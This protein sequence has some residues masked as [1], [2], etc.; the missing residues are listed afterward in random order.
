MLPEEKKTILCWHLIGF[1]LNLFKQTLYLALLRFFCY[2]RM[3]YVEH[4]HNII[5]AETT[6]TMSSE[7]ML[8]KSAR[9]LSL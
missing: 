6:I 1:K 2:G 9:T 7:T 4:E 3:F 5:M 8:K